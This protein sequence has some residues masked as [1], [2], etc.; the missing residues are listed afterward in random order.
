M[1]ETL[2][3][4]CHKRDYDV[5]LRLNGAATDQHGITMSAK[6][7]AVLPPALE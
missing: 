3:L 1:Q 6:T 5:A 2:P 4:C 7:H